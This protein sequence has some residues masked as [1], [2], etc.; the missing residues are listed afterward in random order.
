MDPITR[1]LSILLL[2][3]G[4]LVVG[5]GEAAAQARED[6]VT[7]EVT[8]Q[9]RSY[10]HV[11]LAPLPSF[12]AGPGPPRTVSTTYSVVTNDPE[13]RRLVASVEGP[14]PDGVMVWI[15]LEPPEGAAPA[16]DEAVQVVGP[17]ADRG[18]T[19][20]VTGIEQVSAT[21]LDVRY[22][23]ETTVA[24]DPGDKQVRLEFELVP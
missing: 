18:P 24:A 4:L 23:M 21:D 6:E 15:E 19:P 3:G 5:P 13:P 12:A 11:S 8:A 22:T 1:G 9:V 7:H 14:T 2:G 10:Q 20:L 16:G 17:D